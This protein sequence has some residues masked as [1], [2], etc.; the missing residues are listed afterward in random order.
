M[1][2]KIT[3]K[4]NTRST[5]N[6]VTTFNNTPKMFK[7][8]TKDTSKTHIGFDYID[9]KDTKKDTITMEPLENYINCETNGKTLGYRHLVKMDA[10]VWTNSMCNKLGRLSEG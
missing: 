4:Y 8:D 3:Y 1:A 2:R 10:P 5:V 9:H 6:H 7:M